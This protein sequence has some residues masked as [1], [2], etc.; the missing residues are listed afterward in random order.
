MIIQTLAIFNLLRILPTFHKG[1]V[2]I[3]KKWVSS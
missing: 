2:K 3:T 1:D